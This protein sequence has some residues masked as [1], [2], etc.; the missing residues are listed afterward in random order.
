MNHHLQNLG[1]VVGFYKLFTFHLQFVL[2]RSIIPYN[3]QP[4][5]NG[6]SALKAFTCMNLEKSHVKEYNGI[7]NDPDDV[8]PKVDTLVT[9]NSL[10]CPD[11]NADYVDS[12]VHAHFVGDSLSGVLNDLVWTPTVACLCLE[13]LPSPTSNMVPHVV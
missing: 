1:F 6:T 13:L 2:N 12:L 5:R 7:L 10:L 11:A 9:M 3:P 8:K 4:M